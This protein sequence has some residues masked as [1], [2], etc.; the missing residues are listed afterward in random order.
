MNSEELADWLKHNVE[1][2]ASTLSLNATKVSVRHVLNWG[3]FV[4]HS[5]HVTD[6]VSRYHLKL[7]RQDDSKRF[8]TWLELHRTLEARYRAPEL[9]TRVDFSDIG[10]SGLVFRH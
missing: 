6:G 4:N 10:F 5:F 2:R 8:D 9:I 1:R 7:A 3:G